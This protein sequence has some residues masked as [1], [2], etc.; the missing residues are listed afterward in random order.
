MLANTTEQMAEFFIP[1]KGASEALSYA[2]M[3][4]GLQAEFEPS[5]DPSLRY[6]QESIQG[7]LVTE[8][9][10]RYIMNLY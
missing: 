6:L 10:G 9:D 7:T 2:H 3:M 5:F 8:A 1:I 4:T